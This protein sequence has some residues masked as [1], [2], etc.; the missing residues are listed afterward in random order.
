ML[1]LKELRSQ[2]GVSQQVVADFLGTSRQ[3]YSNYEN[4]NRTPDTET[5]LKLAEF[6]NVSTD[7]IL[8]GTEKT[9]T[10]NSGLEDTLSPAFFRL[11]KG[12]EP[13]N[14]SE[15]D[16]DFLLAVYKAH[17]EKNRQEQ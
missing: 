12:L 5:L 13:Y 4:G 14:I 6:F 17:I 16:A 2:K 10:D 3:A 11:K 1:Y 7:V 15:A 8:R 9:S